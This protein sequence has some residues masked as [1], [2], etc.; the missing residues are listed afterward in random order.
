M[1]TINLLDEDLLLWKEFLDGNTD[2]FA[3]LM[4]LHYQDLFDYGSRFTKDE[5]LIKDRIQELFLESWA[6]RQVIVETTFVKY[7]LL[8]LLRKKLTGRAGRRRHRQSGGRGQKAERPI[9]SRDELQFESIFSVGSLP[10]IRLPREEYLAGLS[11]KM[12][13]V[14]LSLSKRQQEIIYLRWYVEADVG[15][16]AG[17][18]ALEGPTVD[19]LLQEAIR[20]LRKSCARPSRFFLFWQTS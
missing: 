6:E 19:N 9:G 15:D 7:Y 14:L 16:I 17:I 12:R 13:K 4:R 11:R 2:A 20:K 10:D 5:E 1:S 8:T 18:M 3:D